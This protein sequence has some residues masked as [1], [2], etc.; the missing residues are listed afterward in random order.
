[1]LSRRVGPFGA[2]SSEA[3]EKC[4]VR[5]TAPIENI[6]REKIYKDA[7]RFIAAK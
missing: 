5:E 7:V 3:H 6:C 2:G 4:G 1:M